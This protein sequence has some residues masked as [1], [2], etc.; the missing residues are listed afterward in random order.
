MTASLA[1]FAAVDAL[2]N[3]GVRQLLFNATATWQ[4]SNH[5]FGVIFQREGEEFMSGAAASPRLSVSMCISDAP[6]IAKGVAGLCIHGQQVRVIADVIP[7]ASGWATFA[8]EVEG[9]GNASA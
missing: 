5:A 3:Q 1:P 9:G 7:D 2:I 8:V 6:G 4:G